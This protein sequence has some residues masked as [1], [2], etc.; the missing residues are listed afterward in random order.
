[1]LTLFFVLIYFRWGERGRVCARGEVVGAVPSIPERGRV[2]AREE[3][4][5]A[6][7]SIP[8]LFL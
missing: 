6:V 2:C 3:E 4:V 8:L 5:G 1:M 7:P